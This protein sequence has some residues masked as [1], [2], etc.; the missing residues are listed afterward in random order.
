MIKV[1]LLKPGI[2]IYD[3][4][5]PGGIIDIQKLGT[6]RV[7]KPCL[8]EIFWDK[9]SFIECMGEIKRDKEE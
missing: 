5:N 3:D 4:S 2:A 1:N 8:Y 7:I 6:N 9:K